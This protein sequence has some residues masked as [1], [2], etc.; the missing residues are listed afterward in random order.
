M[1]TCRPFNRRIL[2]IRIS[3][4]IETRDSCWIQRER[5]TVTIL[6]DAGAASFVAVAVSL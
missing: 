6:G 2:S 4:S 3:G 5:R 1:S